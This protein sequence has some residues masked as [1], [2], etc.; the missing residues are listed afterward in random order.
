MARRQTPKTLRPRPEFDPRFRYTIPETADLLRQS[1][2]RTWAAIAD[3]KIRVIRDG[4]RTFVP[5][6]EILRLSR[7]PGTAVA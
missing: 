5:G 6:S 4:G 2:S 1:E 7:L 3:K